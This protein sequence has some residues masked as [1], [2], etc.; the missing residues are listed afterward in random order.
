[1]ARTQKE[2]DDEK[3]AAKLAEI[4][5]QVEAGH[6]SIRKMTA[7]ERK[8]YSPRPRGKQAPAPGRKGTQG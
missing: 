4:D 7:E 5:A 1:M 6:L 8:R 2:R 3:R